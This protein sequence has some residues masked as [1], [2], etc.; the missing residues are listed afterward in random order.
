MNLAQ[1]RFPWWE[2]ID[3]VGV[4]ALTQVGRRD[5][6]RVMGTIIGWAMGVERVTPGV[7]LPGM[8]EAPDVRSL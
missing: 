3:G 7:S 2:A 1:P 5:R 6:F 8:T 4:Q